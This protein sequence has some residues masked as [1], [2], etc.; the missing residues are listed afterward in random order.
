MACPLLTRSLARGGTRVAWRISSCPRA[1][2]DPEGCPVGYVI[3]PSTVLLEREGHRDGS[4]RRDRCV[5]PPIGICLP[6]PPP[7]SGS[8]AALSLSIRSPV[9]VGWR[10]KMGKDLT[11]R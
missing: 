8:T 1:F 10:G 7:V 4:R 3:P 9:Y 11:R 5:P 6:A 2:E